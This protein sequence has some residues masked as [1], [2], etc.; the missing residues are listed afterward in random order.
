MRAL[1]YPF[2]EKAV[3]ELRVGERVRVSGRIFTA[4][5]RLHKYLAEGGQTPVSLRDG[6][7][8]HCGPVTVPSGDGWRV[9]AA[10]PTTSIR[11]EPYMAAIIRTCG[12]RVVVGKGGMGAK[13]VEACREH[14]CVY[15]QATGG[16]AVLL[17]QRFRRVECVHFLNEF[18][19]A[20]ALWVLEADNL[21]TIVGIDAEGHSQYDDIREQSKAQLE[22]RIGIV[23]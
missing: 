5:D 9:V 12:V 23:L 16:T 4:R 7:I 2:S 21:E 20:E 6:A 11:E 19:A 18:G 13:T 10:G 8:F 1:I 14:G 15:L 22:K 17:A 3:R